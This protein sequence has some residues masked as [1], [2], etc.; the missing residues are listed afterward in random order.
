MIGEPHLVA[1]G[2]VLEL[3]R[4]DGGAGSVAGQ[5]QEAERVVGFEADAVVDVEA[6][7]G[8]GEHGAGVVLAQE[9]APDEL[10]QHGSTESLREDVDLV[11]AEVQEGAVGSEGAVGDDEVQMGVP[12]HEAAEGLNGGDDAGDEVRLAEAGAQKVAQRA[13]GDAAEDAEE[14][15]VVEEEG[16]QAF[17]D[18]EDELAVGDGV[19]EHVLEPVGPDFEPLGVAGGAEDA[20]LAAEGDEE[21]GVAALAAQA[22]EAA[23]WSILRLLGMIVYLQ[24]KETRLVG[25]GC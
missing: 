22:C 1:G 7:V 10:S 6:G 5:L 14:L 12:V 24:V 19:E 18:G 11:V 21:L 13:V 23:R 8:P 4:G 2:Q 17:G 25:V 16:P 9:I 20:G 15:A 3:W